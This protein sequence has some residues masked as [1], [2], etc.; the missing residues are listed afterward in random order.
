M[1]D[2]TLAPFVDALA[3]ALIMMVLVA[4]FFLLQSITEIEAA[5]KV[6]AVSPNSLKGK[7]FKP[8]FFHV[9]IKVNMDKKEILYMSNFD[10]SE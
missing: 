6:Y 5:A 3:S 4:V 7:N 10:L 8:I 2:N 9:P 1:D